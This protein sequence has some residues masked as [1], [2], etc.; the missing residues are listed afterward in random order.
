[1]LIP[2]WLP[3]GLQLPQQERKFWKYPSVAIRAS[4]IIW[5]VAEGLRI[6]NQQ[7]RKFKRHV[8]EITKVWLI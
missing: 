4:A 5:F 7:Q 1:M 6:Q 8:I 2:C 3:V